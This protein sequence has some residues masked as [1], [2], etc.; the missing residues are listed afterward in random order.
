MWDPRR[1]LN[2]QRWSDFEVN[3][4]ATL[5]AEIHALKGSVVDAISIAIMTLFQFLH[6]LFFLGIFLKRGELSLMGTI[7]A[8]EEGAFCQFWLIAEKR[9]ETLFAVVVTAT[10]LLQLTHHCGQC[11]SLSPPCGHCPWLSRS[12]PMFRRV[13][14]RNPKFWF[15]VSTKRHNLVSKW[16]E[17]GIRNSCCL[18]YRNFKI[19]FQKGWNLELGF[20]IFCFNEMAQIRFRKGWNPES[21][22]PIFCFNEMAQFSLGFPWEWTTHPNGKEWKTKR[23]AREKETTV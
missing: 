21:G 16:L 6:M 13:G 17:S 12:W 11:P 23:I 22:F 19:R 15:F 9:R 3:P 1:G 4:D 8:F 14:I 10:N 2:L 20:L 7:L 18:F 5:Q